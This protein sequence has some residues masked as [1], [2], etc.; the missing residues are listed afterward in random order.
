ME[1]FDPHK[2]LTRFRFEKEFSLVGSEAPGISFQVQM[3]ESKLL[4]AP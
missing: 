2:C 4:K 3:E 1:M